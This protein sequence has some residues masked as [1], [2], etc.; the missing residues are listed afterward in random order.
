MFQFAT[1]TG[2]LKPAIRELAELP[3]ELF[4]VPR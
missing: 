4:E 2:K 1:L 3:T